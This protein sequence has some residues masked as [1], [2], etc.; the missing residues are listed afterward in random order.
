MQ[1]FVSLFL[2][3]AGEKRFGP[4]AHRSPTG[5][6]LTPATSPLSPTAALL[7]L[8]AHSDPFS[9]GKLLESVQ[10]ALGFLSS[11]LE[12]RGKKNWITDFRSFPGPKERGFPDD[13]CSGGEGSR[14]MAPSGGGPG[15]STC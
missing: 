13:L 15:S 9:G 7:H 2:L 6:G 4:R 3:L 11:C 14:A 1:L 12:N 10:G 8:S 5:T